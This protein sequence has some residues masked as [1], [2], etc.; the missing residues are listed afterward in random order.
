MCE[1]DRQLIM[2]NT[3]I[4]IHSAASVRFNDSLKYSI[5]M[6]V[7]GT[8]EIVDLASEIKDL[9]VFVHVPTTFCNTDKKVIEEKLYSP[10]ADWRSSIELAEKYDDNI[11]NT[12]ASKFIDPLPNT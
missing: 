8:R 11:L 3:Q 6:N 2:N 10:H 7:R 4:I 12:M 9:S 5:I 1:E